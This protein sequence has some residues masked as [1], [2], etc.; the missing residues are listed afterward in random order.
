MIS[1]FIYVIVQSGQFRVFSNQ[2]LCL[3]FMASERAIIRR[4]W[5]FC[6]SI[7]GGFERLETRFVD[8]LNRSAQDILYTALHKDQI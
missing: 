3:Y 4:D 7:D 8:G 1:I 6:L 5:L 2:S